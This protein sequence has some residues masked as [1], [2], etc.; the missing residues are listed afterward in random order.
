MSQRVPL[1]DDADDP[2]GQKTSRR[3]RSDAALNRAR[4]LSAARRLLAED[5]ET[6]MSQIAESTGL[7]RGTVH[8]HFATRE[9]LMEAVRRQA[10]DDAESDEEDYLR[11]PGEVANVMSSPLSIAD[12]LNKVPP[13]QLGEQ[14]V[15]E[16]QRLPGISSAAIY[17][18]D[19]DGASM[20]RFAGSPVFPDK[21]M[22]PLA[23]GPE[24]PREGVAAIRAVFEE[25]LPGATVAPLHLR[26]RAI[27][28]LL[29]VG[30]VTHELRD[31]AAEAAIALSLAPDYTDHV[32]T[33]RRTRPTSP[34]AEIQQNLLPPRIARIGGATLAGNVIPGYEIGGDW[35]DYAENPQG[36][37]I[38]IAD[39]DG[40]GAAA[41]GVGAVTLGAFRS[42]R[43]NSTDP[44]DSITAMHQTL[45]ELADS[46]A[47]SSATIG[48]WNA[49][50]SSFRWVTAGHQPLIRVT[51]SGDLELL[52]QAP[53]P[54]LGTDDFPDT[55]TV[56]ETRIRTGER[57]LLLSDGV[58]G[59]LDGTQ[60]G[61][62]G[63]RRAAAKSAG[64]TAPATVRA[65]EDLVRETH[66][67]H[68]TDDAAMIVLA[69]SGMLGSN[70]F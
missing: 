9:D 61:L 23:V 53:L 7:G 66:P 43:R 50:A 6:S 68:L 24:I 28:V 58:T 38:G 42:I 5:G 40:S 1:P 4:I 52:E 65:I 17:V 11:P 46:R 27:G 45:L 60:P 56:N 64:A 44:A 31:L 13:F 35:F 67:D 41:A 18:V 8:R 29:A 54:M 47:T 33:M 36:A 14:I 48:L 39:S 16:A 63:I 22:V 30:T 37:W 25:L 34:A 51:E 59:D 26:G 20:Q 49:P 21:V 10:R 19:L 15:A 2:S 12:V 55:I 69:P 32:D 57:L 70:D 3:Q 62:A